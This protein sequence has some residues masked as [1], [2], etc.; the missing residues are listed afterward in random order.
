M[1]SRQKFNSKNWYSLSLLV[2]GLIGLVASLWQASER[3]HMLKNPDI[4][5]G[6]NLN[7]VVS[8]SSVLDHPLSAVFGFPNSFLGIV[9]FVFLFASGLALLAGGENLKPWFW[10]IQ[11]IINV[12]LLGFAV[13]FF[14]VSLYVIGN[15]CIFCIFIWLSAIVIS[16]Y[17]F[18][19]HVSNQTYG[20]MKKLHI[21]KSISDWHMVVPIAIVIVMVILVLIRFRYYYFS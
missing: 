12:A 11:F 8:C 13:W 9:F 5:L 1:V 21:P 20:F 6:C 15:L 10:K 16:W 4:A 19:W 17:G 7:P 14:S 2:G 18:W 3:V